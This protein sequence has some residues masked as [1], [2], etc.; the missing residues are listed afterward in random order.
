V[1][2]STSSLEYDY[3]LALAPNNPWQPDR[4]NTKKKDRE[5]EETVA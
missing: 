5:K 1:Y 2:G 4:K 3:A